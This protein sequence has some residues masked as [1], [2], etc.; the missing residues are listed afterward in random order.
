MIA[1]TDLLSLSY[2]SKSISKSLLIKDKKRS[3]TSE[4]LPIITNT[5]I[6]SEK[7]YTYIKYELNMSLF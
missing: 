1:I 5:F 7:L 6:L 4:I 2:L 3:Q